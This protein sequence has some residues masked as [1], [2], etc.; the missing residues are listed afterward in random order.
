MEKIE[1]EEDDEKIIKEVNDLI[2]EENKVDEFNEENV[3]FL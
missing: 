1:Y 3:D 2:D